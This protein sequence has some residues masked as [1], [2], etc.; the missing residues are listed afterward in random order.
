[1][2]R[3]LIDKETAIKD[4]V[5]DFASHGNR[6]IDAY[7]KGLEEYLDSLKANND[8]TCH[9]LMKVFENAQRDRA[10]TSK[11]VLKQQVQNMKAQ[12]ERQQEAVMGRM[13][14]ALAACAE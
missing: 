2:I 10:V 3:H 14:A 6:L 4:M 8:R 9:N 7:E 11:A 13:A 12:R 5:T 1:M